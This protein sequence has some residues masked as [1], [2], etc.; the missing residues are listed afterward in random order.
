MRISGG[1]LFLDVGYS[2]RPFYQSLCAEEVFFLLARL[3]HW[4]ILRLTKTG[5][6]A[7]GRL[8]WR[9]FDA[10]LSSAASSP[11][12]GTVYQKQSVGF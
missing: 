1:T 6:R 2:T 4:I 8:L 3:S 12:L 11:I 9:H 10:R 5:S 7:L